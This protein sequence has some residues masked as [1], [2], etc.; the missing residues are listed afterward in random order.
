MAQTTISN[1]TYVTNPS[2]I[3]DVKV[4][5]DAYDALTAVLNGEEV[6]RFERGTSMEPILKDGEYAHL[7]PL[8][9]LDEVSIG[10]A[11]FCKVHGYLMTHMV[12]MKS[13]SGSNQ[14]YF[15]IGSSHYDF[16]GWT[17]Q[18]YAKAYGTNV[19]ETPEDVITYE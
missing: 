7:K 18:I 6:M 15:L 8:Q 1:L 11:V 12:L 10:D 4:V 5:N 14:P 2:E 9:S 16:Y 13:S 19:I 17:N 3:N